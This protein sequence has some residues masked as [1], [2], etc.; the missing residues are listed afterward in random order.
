[1]MEIETGGLLW[2][3]VKG[4]PWVATRGD[5]VKNDYHGYAIDL[6]PDLS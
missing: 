2:N 5:C 4:L 3:G 6:L 1:M